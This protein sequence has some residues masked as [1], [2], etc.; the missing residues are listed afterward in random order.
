[1][2]NLTYKQRY[3]GVEWLVYLCEK[4]D[5]QVETIMNKNKFDFVLQFSLKKDLPATSFSTLK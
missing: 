2:S 4:K 1:M 3:S 5:F